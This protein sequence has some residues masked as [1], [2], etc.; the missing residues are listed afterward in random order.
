MSLRK[1]KI[2]SV[3]DANVKRTQAWDSVG[4]CGFENPWTRRFFHYDVELGAVA[5][6]R[7]I[8]LCPGVRHLT[9]RDFWEHLRMSV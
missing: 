4:S 5:R 2:P 6:R 9:H 7:I 3:F 1:E 8:G